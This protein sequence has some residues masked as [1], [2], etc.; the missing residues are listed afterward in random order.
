MLATVS[1]QRGVGVAPSTALACALLVGLAGAQVRRH[2]LFAPSVSERLRPTRAHVVRLPRAH[3]AEG[4]RRLGEGDEAP[5]PEARSRTFGAPLPI[6]LTLDSAG[7]WEV[8]PGGRHIWRLSL[9]CPGAQSMHIFAD[10]F[11]LR[12]GDRLFAH[13]GQGVGARGAYTHRNNNAD[14]S[15]ATPPVPGDSLHLEL[16]TPSVH[17]GPAPDRLLGLSLLVA[18]TT[19][20][21]GTR[22]WEAVHGHRLPLGPGALGL[23]HNP[24]RASTQRGSS[25][26]DLRVPMPPADGA[27]SPSST[28]KGEG[29]G[30]PESPGM[31]EKSSSPLVRI[32]SWVSGSGDCMVNEACPEGQPWS[33]QAAGVAAIIEHRT[34]S[35]CSGTLINSLGNTKPRQF[36]L[37]AFHCVRSRV[38]SR[39]FD[40]EDNFLPWSFLF[41]WQSATCAEDVLPVMGSR[42]ARGVDS[43]YGATVRA[44]GNDTDFALLEI[45]EPIPDEYNVHYNGWDASGARPNMS[46]IIH[47]P[48]SD[49]KKVTIDYD[50]PRTRIFGGE[51]YYQMIMG[52][53]RVWHSPH[54]YV[55]RYEVGSTEGG[56][57]GGPLFDHSGRLVGVLHGGYAD[58]SSPT[59]DWYGKLVNFF[60]E[61][62]QWGQG[63]KHGALLAW[64]DPENT[65]VRVTD[66]EWL[67]PHANVQRADAG[68]ELSD[69]VLMFEAGGRH[70]ARSISASLLS[71]PEAPVRLAASMHGPGSE[72]FQVAVPVAATID[73]SSWEELTWFSITWPDEACTPVACA[74]LLHVT[75]DDPM[76]SLDE[77]LQVA[78]FPQAHAPGAPTGYEAVG[79][80]ASVPSARHRLAGHGLGESAE[81]CHAPCAEQGWDYFVL[82]QSTC[83]CLSAD[84]VDRELPQDQLPTHVCLD[85]SVRTYELYRS[86]AMGHIF[87]GI[88]S[89]ASAQHLR[90]Q[91]RPARPAADARSGTRQGV[92]A[93]VCVGIIALVVGALSA[94]VRRRLQS[95][96]SVSVASVDHSAG[97]QGAEVL[98]RHQP[99]EQVAYASRDQ[100]CGS[101]IQAHSGLGGLSATML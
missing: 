96:T 67:R 74:L 43:V 29:G 75:S 13:N 100:R 11:R 52:T 62:A 23:V 60:E 18:G 42:A 99:R 27:A 85:D 78:V 54:W 101:R 49:L 83:F 61:S 38:E 58:C 76:Y 63:A 3:L 19:P 17:R 21:F 97:R 39:D 50:A 77:P 48:T 66:G 37:T 87:P 16:T 91:P 55:E 34:A 33:A 88:G 82:S 12:P 24:S 57:S 35:I 59:A 90:H 69:R 56:S 41:N 20:L 81:A 46:L 36:F 65:G 10:Q 4:R 53:K 5:S 1:G 31:A 79:C 70:A 28:R 73:P 98:P 14:L 22:A 8:L 9:R 72:C 51:G 94:T 71:R 30:G 80:F 15:F 25:H 47:H 64:L 89:L 44:Y 86:T 32:S 7:D 26:T 40:P 6:N 2:D 92:T 95:R 93:T 68:I 84:A 45:H